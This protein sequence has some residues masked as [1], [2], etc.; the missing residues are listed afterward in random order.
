MTRSNSLQGAA[1]V[2]ILSWSQNIKF[3]FQLV[4]Q[5]TFKDR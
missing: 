1:Q 4:F 5:I 3:N 2:N